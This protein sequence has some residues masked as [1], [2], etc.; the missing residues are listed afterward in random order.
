MILVLKYFILSVFRL[1]QLYWTV[2]M[3]LISMLP[4]SNSQN[5]YVTVWH[6]SNMPRNVGIIKIAQYIKFINI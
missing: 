3:K 5:T 2:L 4:I 1:N 6:V